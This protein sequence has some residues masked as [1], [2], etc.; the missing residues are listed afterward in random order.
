MVA[1][2]LTDQQSRHTSSDGK[3]KEL[4]RKAGEVRYMEAWE[5]N[6]ENMSDKPF[7]LIA[8]ELKS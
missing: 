3:T 1:I 8:V 2:F 4:S 5:H 6:P 7:E